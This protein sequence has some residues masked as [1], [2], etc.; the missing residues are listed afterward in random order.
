[1][2]ILKNLTGECGKQT[3]PGT[4]V[5]LY[6]TCSCELNGFPSVLTTTVAGDSV[7]LDGPFDFSTAPVGEGY[8]RV[9]DILINT[10]RITQ[11]VEGEVGGQGVAGGMG[12]T[13][14]GSNAAQLEF[15]ENLVKAS[16]C[17]VGMMKQRGHTEYTVMGSEEIPAVV[18]EGTMDGG[19]N[20]GDIN[21]T[22]Y[23]LKASTGLRMYDADTH[24]IDIIPNP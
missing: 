21:G 14:V 9:A 17:I 18:T 23:V 12:F 1:M 4:T 15:Q 3:P 20:L 24:G 10:G 16:G 7:R 5:K 8:W 2:A 22:P 11:A 6:Y 19:A 13:V